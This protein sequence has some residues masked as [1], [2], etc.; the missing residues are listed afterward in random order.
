MAPRSKSRADVPEDAGDDATM[1]DAPPSHQP[2]AEDV[3]DAEGGEAGDDEMN[4]DED[5]EEEEEEP[6]RVKLVCFCC[7]LN[8]GY[9]W[10][11]WLT[12]YSSLVRQ[13]PRL[14]LSLRMKATPLAMLCGTSS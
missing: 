9:L 11:A 4:Q 12:D 13:L 1:Q 10:T 8:M 5:Y 2:A 3:E 14:R 6:Q 7:L